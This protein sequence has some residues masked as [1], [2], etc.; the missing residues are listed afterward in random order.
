[1]T[2]IEALEQ[3]MYG[4]FVADATL[5]GIVGTAVYSDH[6]PQNGDFPALVWQIL[7]GEPVNVQMNRRCGQRFLVQLKAVDRSKS[8]VHLYPVL[9]AAEPVL[10]AGGNVGGFFFTVIKN[11]SVSDKFVDKGIEWAQVI[12]TYEIWVRTAPV[13]E[14]ES[15]DSG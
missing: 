13:A 4:S 1:M 2:E 9:G 10:M 11:D 5:A 14:D 7:A 8:K 12:D 6:V 3:W 15:E